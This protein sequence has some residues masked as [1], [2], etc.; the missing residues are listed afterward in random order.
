[1]LWTIVLAA[2]ASAAIP[3]A[4]CGDGA[5]DLKQ[6]DCI[7]AVAAWKAG[8]Q[9]AA[10]DPVAIAAEKRLRDREDA[11]LL[12]RFPSQEAYWKARQADLAPLIASIKITEA[13][14]SNLAHERAR[15]NSE[16]EFYPDGRWPSMLTEAADAIDVTLAANCRI[17]ANQQ[18]RVTRA[19]ALYD[20]QLARLG[21]LWRPTMA[22]TQPSAGGQ[23][24]RPQQSPCGK[25]ALAAN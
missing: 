17:I 10:P 1:M 21:P 20:M 19:T 2:A 18:A 7:V 5:S 25:N 14:V 16:K 24:L 22:P 12:S 13:R 9:P 8:W 15:V 11:V 6:I 3:I 23:Y 4:E